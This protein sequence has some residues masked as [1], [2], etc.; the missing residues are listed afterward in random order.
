M[1]KSEQ[2]G[3]KTSG[4]GFKKVIPVRD[5]SRTVRNNPIQ[6]Y[7]SKGLLSERIFTHRS[8]EKRQVTPSNVASDTAEAEKMILSSRYSKESERP[9]TN[10]SIVIDLISV[11]QTL[12]GELV[13]SLIRTPALPSALRSPE[14]MEMMINDSAPSVEMPLPLYRDD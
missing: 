2:K 13:A 4:G 9:H 14:Q 7:S 6:V 8:E 10:R 11:K 12:S 5:E 3:I 1:L